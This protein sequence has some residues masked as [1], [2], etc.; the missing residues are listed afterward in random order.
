MQE[1]MV[2]LEMPPEWT[3]YS[4]VELY[5]AETKSPDT[6]VLNDAPATYRLWSADEKGDG[7][8]YV[9]DSW[10]NYV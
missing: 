2:N 6:S 5:V 9:K 1:I 4:D 3:G 7:Y 8:E 10:K